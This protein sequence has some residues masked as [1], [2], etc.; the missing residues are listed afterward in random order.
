MPLN[1]CP[2]HKPDAKRA[3][4]EGKVWTANGTNGETEGRSAARGT[5][6]AWK[7]ES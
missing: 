3:N 1:F 4:R 6:I 7:L 2:D 5:G